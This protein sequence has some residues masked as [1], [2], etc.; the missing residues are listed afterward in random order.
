MGMDTPVMGWTDLDWA[1]FHE[2]YWKV[3]LLL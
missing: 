3:C 2:S 1:H